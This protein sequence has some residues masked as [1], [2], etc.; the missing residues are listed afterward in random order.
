MNTEKKLYR[1]RDDRRIAGV[2]GGLG[3]FLNIEPR[4]LRWAFVLTAEVT[5][6]IYILMW[7]YLDEEPVEQKQDLHP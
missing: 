4:L 2:C 3:K 5:A 7:I 6:P 1:S